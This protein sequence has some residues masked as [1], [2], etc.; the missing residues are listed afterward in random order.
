MQR[1]TP[2]AKNK[3]DQK[4]TFS[5]TLLVFQIVAESQRFQPK[6]SMS[7]NSHNPSQSK[8]LPWKLYLMTNK[9]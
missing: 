7:P 1:K 5:R 2:E 8:I 4:Q 9:K 6:H 3:T